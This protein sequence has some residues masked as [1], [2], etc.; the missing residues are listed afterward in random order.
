MTQV[1]EAAAEPDDEMIVLLS[2][3]V[4][5][6][7]APDKRAEVDKKIASDEAW[8]VAHA[9]IVETRNALSGLQ[10]ARAP[11]NFTED[12][13]GTIHKRSAGRFFAKRTFGDRVPFG[14]ILIVALIAMAIIAYI[15]WT[16]PTGSLKRDKEHEP[17]TG[18]SL[19]P[20]V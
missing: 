4:D 18:S 2:D 3:Y 1:D 12:V 14:A 8:K 17:K 11:V 6:T 9:E 20:R 16:S 10:K 19:V 5:G 7:L 13:T 15:L